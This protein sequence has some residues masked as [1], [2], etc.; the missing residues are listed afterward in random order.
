MQK[1]LQMLF[2]CLGTILLDLLTER[3]KNCWLGFFRSIIILP[4]LLVEQEV[5][6]RLKFVYETFAQDDI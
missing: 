5:L 3:N 1:L 4:H 6:H 2:H